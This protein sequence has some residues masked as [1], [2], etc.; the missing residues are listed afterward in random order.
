MKID[1]VIYKYVYSYDVPGLS[2][3]IAILENEIASFVNNIF[4]PFLERYF[5]AVSFLQD[6]QES[7]P[8]KMNLTFIRI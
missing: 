2:K 1:S 8:M 3:N 7:F 6:L 5:D 4:L